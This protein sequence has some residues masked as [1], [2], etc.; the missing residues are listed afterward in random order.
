[1][2][3]LTD[4][5]EWRFY[6]PG[7]Q[8]RYDERMV[9]KLD[10]LE[11]NIEDAANRLERY[12][13]YEKVCSGEALQ[14]TRSDYQAVAKDREIK[15]TLPRAWN[16]LLKE[17]DSLLL[18]YLAEKVADLCG[19]KP[20]LNSCGQF[21][22]RVSNPDIGTTVSTLKQTTP[23]S[24]KEP[25][26]TDGVHEKRS[27]VS[28]VIKGE[29]Y[30]SKSAKEVMCKVFQF[31]IK[32]DADFPEKFSPLPYGKKRR[33]LARDRRELYPRSPHLAEEKS[34]EVA[35]GWWL[36]TNFSREVIQEILNKAL[37]VVHPRVRSQIQVNIDN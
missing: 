9:Y 32:E 14:A 18:E 2:A 19:Y 33:Y 34:T 24:V 17:P 30:E 20:D 7:G 13:S 15:D 26:E 23:L 21:L 31:V 11:R 4:G 8:G 3:I 27:V 37:A 29:T 36:A 22:E 12:L 6:L 35:P 5:K 1:M 10:L 16:A 28:C 25:K